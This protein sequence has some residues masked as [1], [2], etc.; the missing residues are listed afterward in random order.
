[1]EVEYAKSEIID[2]ITDFFGYNCIKS[3]KLKIIQDKIKINFKDNSE[4]KDFKE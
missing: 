2:K 4:I 3:V 1:M